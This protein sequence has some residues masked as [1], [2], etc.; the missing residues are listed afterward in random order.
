MPRTHVIYSVGNPEPTLIPFTPEEE[1]AADAA[2]TAAA[3]AANDPANF[4]LSMR[5]LRLGLKQFAGKP[6]SFI[7]DIINGMTD[8]DAKDE[9]QI[10]YEETSVVHWDHLMTQ[11]LI[12]LAGIAEA[13]AKAMWLAARS[14]PA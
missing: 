13:D 7:Q 4:P 10:W 3:E 11:T 2:A 14:I 5:Q 1:A 8:P 12:S 9:A 6:A